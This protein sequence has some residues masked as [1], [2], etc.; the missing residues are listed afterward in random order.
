M[1]IQSLNIDTGELINFFD[2][3]ESGLVIDADPAHAGIDIN[4]DLD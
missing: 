3:I 1:G 4:M 2:N